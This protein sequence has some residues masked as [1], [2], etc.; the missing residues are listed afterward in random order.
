MRDT[1]VSVK[2]RRSKSA[3][4]NECPDEPED[5]SCHD[6][7]H[8]QITPTPSRYVAFIFKVLTAKPPRPLVKIAPS[9]NQNDIGCRTTSSM[10][11]WSSTISVRTP[12]R[13]FH[14]RSG[15]K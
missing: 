14:H 13:V 15:L 8:G 1:M 11:F 6:C 9:R 10:S 12:L 5:N 4:I 2:K 7:S 3:R